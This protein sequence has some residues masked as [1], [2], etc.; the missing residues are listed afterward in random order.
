MA[1]FDDV[2]INGN[3]VIGGGWANVSPGIPRASLLQDDL[4]TY[5]IPLTDFRVWDA[6]HTNLPGTSATDDLALVGGTFTS[7]SPTIQTSD[8]QDAG[9]TSRYARVMIRIPAEYVGAQTVTLRF[10]AGMKTNPADVSATLDVQAYASDEEEGVSADLCSTAA[11]TINS[12]T[13]A[14]K[15]FLI[16]PTALSA[17]DLLDVR[18]T[19]A[20]NDAATGAEVIGIIGAVQLLCDVKG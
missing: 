8:L 12:T 7:A 3:T 5:T 19:V 2:R 17:G 6:L 16:T 10:H 11:T 1:T 4:A 14:D 9:A 13:M 20:V 18:I 15:D